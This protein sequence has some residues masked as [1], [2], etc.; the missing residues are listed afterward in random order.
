MEGEEQEQGSSFAWGDLFKDV[1]GSG[2]SYAQAAEARKAAE[3]RARLDAATAQ[4][5]SNRLETLARLDTQLGLGKYQSLAFAGVALVVVL[6]LLRQ[7][8]G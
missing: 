7:Q 1:L 6:L 4:Q 8:K 5:T 2:V 3:T